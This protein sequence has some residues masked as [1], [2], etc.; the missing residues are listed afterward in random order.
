MFGRQLCFRSFN[1]EVG[2]LCG[3]AKILVHENQHT[4]NLPPHPGL[5]Q[6]QTPVSNR[7]KRDPSLP[8][9]HQQTDSDLSFN[10]RNAMT[11]RFH[12]QA[13]RG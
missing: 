6:T 12:P 13:F 2:M 11:Y 7:N 4:P 9:K 8:L 3:L 1:D 10:Y 5:K